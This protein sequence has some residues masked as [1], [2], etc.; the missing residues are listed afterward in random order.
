MRALWTAI[1]GRKFLAFATVVT[2]TAIF[3][4]DAT[5]FVASLLGAFALFVG[6]NALEKFAGKEVDK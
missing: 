6:G 1:G 4:K 2:L 3:V 5:Q